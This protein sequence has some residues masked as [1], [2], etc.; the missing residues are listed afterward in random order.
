MVGI[1][2]QASV[3][4]PKLALQPFDEGQDHENFQ[5]TERNKIQLALE[6]NE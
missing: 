6:M 5:E 2:I 4:F 1:L 3:L